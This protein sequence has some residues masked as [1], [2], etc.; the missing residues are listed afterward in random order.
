[1]VIPT[2]LPLISKAQPFDDPDWL[3]E[4]KY[5]GFRALA[6]IDDGQCRFFSKHK[7]RLTGFRSLGERLVRELRVNNT[8]LDG[9]LVATDELGRTVFAGLMQR[10]HP[11]QYFAFDLLWLN[12]VDLCFLPLLSRKATLKEIVP[13]RSPHMVYVNHTR[14]VGTELYKLACQLDLEGIVAKRIDSRYEENGKTGQWIKI[15]NPS[16]SQKEGRGGSLREKE[17]SRSQ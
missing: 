12:G 10:N 14:A 5:D 8:I 16:Y 3:F 1:M 13:P 11:I 17:V 9:E 7:H 15:N 6:V 2:P 4:I